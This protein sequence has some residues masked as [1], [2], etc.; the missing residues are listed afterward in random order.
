MLE[1]WRAHE[2]ALISQAATSNLSSRLH[3]LD[4][5][6]LANRYRGIRCDG[7]HFGKN[8]TARGGK[9]D[10][11]R[12]GDRTHGRSRLDCYASPAVWDLSLLDVLVR[13]GWLRDVWAHPDQGSV[14]KG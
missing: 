8:Y 6:A 9:W 1:L 4:T 2:I 10:W 5:G 14:G 7:I 11:I 12:P 13:V 3:Y